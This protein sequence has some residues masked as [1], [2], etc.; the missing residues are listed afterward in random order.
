MFKW[1]WE[2]YKIWII[3][4][5]VICILIYIITYAFMMPSNG[6]FYVGDGLS[7]SDWLTFWGGY[8]SFIGTV[9]VAIVAMTQ[10]SYHNE[11]ENRRRAEER[12]KEIQP[13]FVIEIKAIDKIVPGTVEVISPSDPNGGPKHKNVL[14]EI[15][16]ANEK[17]AKNVFFMDHYLG[18]VMKQGEERNVCTVYYDSPDSSRKNT[19][20]I[21]D[22]V[23]RDSEGVPKWLNIYYEDIDGYNMVQMFS[24]NSNM[25]TKFY[26]LD[27]FPEDLGYGLNHKE[28]CKS[29]KRTTSG[30]N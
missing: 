10:S 6:P 27:G 14:L 13:L 12:H 15:Q 17:P 29:E 16:I 21:T 2:K 30:S 25:G 7:K 18:S 28:F 23:E 9:S 1:M 20:L 24:L 3:A 26:Q 8:L 4:F 22:D 19:V 5:V 11:M